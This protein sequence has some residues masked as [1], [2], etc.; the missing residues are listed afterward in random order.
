MLQWQTLG[1]LPAFTRSAAL[2]GGV[3][4]AIGPNKR[5][6]VAFDLASGVCSSVPPSNRHKPT[7]TL[8]AVDELL[9]LI[10]TKGIVSAYD[11]GQRSWSDAGTLRQ[12]MFRSAVAAVGGVVYVIG[13]RVHS[14]RGAAAMRQI[15]RFD[16]AAG[17]SETVALLPHPTSDCQ[18]AVRPDGVGIDILGGDWI[19]GASRLGEPNA[20][21]LDEWLR[22]DASTHRLTEEGVLLQAVSRG[23]AVRDARSRLYVAGGNDQAVSIYDPEAGR[24]DTDRPLPSPGAYAD[25]FVHEGRL[26]VSQSDS[27]QAAALDLPASE[28]TPPPPVA[29]TGAEFVVVAGGEAG[30]FATREEA[31]RVALELLRAGLSAE[32]RER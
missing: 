14:E 22:F 29:P 2:A 24:W 11:P 16:P 1:E 15:E 9:I 4:Y 3:L 28:I 12:P 5:D 19:E 17:D 25:A 20:T 21:V 26:I 30:P 27:V 7:S 8:A 10:G 18:V 31:E 23:G 13:G 6:T 32:I